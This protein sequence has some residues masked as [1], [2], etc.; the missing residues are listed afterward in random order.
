MMSG[1]NLKYSAITKATASESIV[2][3]VKSVWDLKL[4][5]IQLP[6]AKDVV[7]SDILA[8]DNSQ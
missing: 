7:F 4:T 2:I 1:P 6:N 8:T 5:D 3:T